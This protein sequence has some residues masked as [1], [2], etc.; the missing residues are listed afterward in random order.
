MLERS[1]QPGMPYNEVLIDSARYVAQL[2]ATLAA[3]VYGLPGPGNTDSDFVL[4]SFGTDVWGQ[5]EAANAYVW[6]LDAF[7]L[8]ESDVFLLHANE[9]FDRPGATGA[10]LTDHSR[11]ARE[12]VRNHPYGEYRQ[13]W[14]ATHPLLSQHPESYHQLAGRAARSERRGAKQRTERGW[15]RLE[16]SLNLSSYNVTS[17]GGGGITPTAGQHAVAPHP[18]SRIGKATGLAGGGEAVPVG[19]ERAAD[20]ASVRDGHSDWSLRPVV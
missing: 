19:G 8:T 18:L 5:V 3:I 7:N 20:G 16:R 13:R 9:N 17:P 12:F 11:G 2:P 1:L 15:R 6:L 14:A 10:V 4:P